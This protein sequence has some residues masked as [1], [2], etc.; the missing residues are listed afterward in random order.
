[1]FTLNSFRAGGVSPPGE[2]RTTRR[3]RLAFAACLMLVTMVGAAPAAEA[4]PVEPEPGAAATVA[5]T[6]A[7]VQT[8][9]AIQDAAAMTCVAA[10]MAEAEAETPEQLNQADELGR[11][12][13]QLMFQV[14]ICT[15]F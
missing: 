2:A 14:F 12:C 15:F 5:S 4:P 9:D 7:A 6:V 13:R 11:I 8:C 1:M 10:E 3:G